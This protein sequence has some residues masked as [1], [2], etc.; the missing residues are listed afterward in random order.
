MR[1][2]IK[3]QNLRRRIK[4]IECRIRFLKHLVADPQTY[5][6]EVQRRITCIN[7][8][9]ASI[10][11]HE[12]A[13]KRIAAEVANSHQLLMEAESSLKALTLESKKHLVRKYLAEMAAI[14]KALKEM[15]HASPVQGH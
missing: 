11:Q 9:Q 12:T 5:N 10:N 4:C 14:N 1:Q 6:R 8:L 13:L 7:E 2:D 3:E 15:E